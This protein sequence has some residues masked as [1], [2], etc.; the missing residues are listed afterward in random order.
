MLNNSGRSGGGA[1]QVVQVKAVAGMGE[2]LNLG[3]HS[4]LLDS[5]R[6]SPPPRGPNNGTTFRDIP[7]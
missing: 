7:V 5:S 2:G 1:V 3:W 6:C 4:R